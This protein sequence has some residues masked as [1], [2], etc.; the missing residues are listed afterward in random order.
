MKKLTLA[1]EIYV[2]SYEGCPIL[3]FSLRKMRREYF[4]NTKVS[5]NVMYELFPDEYNTKNSKSYGLTPLE[6][7]FLEV[8]YAKLL[9][10]NRCYVIKRRKIYYIFAEE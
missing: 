4:F 2:G 5:R 1:N 6:D 10:G 9:D 8:F 7:R 3:E